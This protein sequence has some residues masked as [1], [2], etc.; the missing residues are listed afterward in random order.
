M[1]RVEISVLFAVI[2]VVWVVGVIWWVMMLVEALKTPG[3]RWSAA[4]QSQLVYILAMV[5]LGVLGTLLYVLIARPRLKAA[6]LAGV[7]TS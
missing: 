2:A 3:G 6:Q 7:G 1:R 5:F 4:D